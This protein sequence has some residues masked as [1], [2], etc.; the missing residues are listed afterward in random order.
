MSARVQ[1][2]DDILAEVELE[3]ASDFRGMKY[4]HDIKCKLCGHIYRRSLAGLAS[5]LLTRG[6]KGCPL[7]V[8][9]QQYHKGRVERKLALESRGIV[10]L[11]EWDGSL[12]RGKYEHVLRW[13]NLKCG[14][15]FE[16]DVERILGMASGCPICM[17]TGN[18]IETAKRIDV[19]TIEALMVHSKIPN[20]IKLVLKDKEFVTNFLE[21]WAPRGA[22]MLTQ[23]LRINRTV[24]A[25]W[26]SAHN[27]EV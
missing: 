14:H 13:K 11:D 26:L 15:E 7:C 25:Q 9:S 19:S 5:G 3:L 12:I 10:C 4:E 17:G 20:E 2:I 27:V 24:T 16:S 6:Y 18:I 22:E 8:K 23:I 1:N 21:D